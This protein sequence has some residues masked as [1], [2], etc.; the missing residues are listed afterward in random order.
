MS[1]KPHSVACFQTQIALFLI[2]S[3]LLLTAPTL[4]IKLVSPDNLYEVKNEIL[5]P[6][7]LSNLNFSIDAQEVEDGVFMYVVFLIS[8]VPVFLVSKNTNANKDNQKLENGDGA[9]FLGNGF[10][11]VFGNSED[12][13][14]EIQFNNIEGLLTEL[15]QRGKLGSIKL[16]LVL[17]MYSFENWPSALLQDSINNNKVILQGISD[18]LFPE[19]GQGKMYVEKREIVHMQA[20]EIESKYREFAGHK[21]KDMLEYHIDEIIKPQRDTAY[22]AKSFGKASHSTIETVTKSTLDAILPMI[23]KSIDSSVRITL[24]KHFEEEFKPIFDKDGLQK[25]LQSELLPIKMNLILAVARSVFYEEGPTEDMVSLSL[26]TITNRDDVYALGQSMVDQALMLYR[27]YAER[28]LEKVLEATLKDQYVIGFLKHIKD[29]ITGAVSKINT[30]VWKGSYSVEMTGDEQKNLVE[31][32]F[33]SMD[34]VDF[35]LS[36]LIDG[37]MPTIREFVT[38][39]IWYNVEYN[40]FSELALTVMSPGNRQVGFMGIMLNLQN[41]NSLVPMAGMGVVEFNVGSREVLFQE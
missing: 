6:F 15:K 39:Y 22:N 20:N 2:L 23:S 27:S 41:Y 38:N 24:N 31:D 35:L 12:V 13:Q 32:L 25:F 3:T 8:R 10:K 11:H 37:V 4:S 1:H 26:D 14:G 36:M 18:K 40:M 5:V 19:E 16:K 7:K 9:I 30:D 29:S 28:K 21:C 34:I 17:P 33:D